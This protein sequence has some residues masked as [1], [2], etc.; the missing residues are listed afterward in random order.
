MKSLIY[1]IPEYKRCTM[2]SAILL[3]LIDDRFKNNYKQEITSN[4]LG[5]TL[6]SA[7]NSVLDSESDMVRSK[8]V[9]MREFENLLNEPIFRDEKIKNKKKKSD[10]FTLEVLKDFIH[11]LKKYV[12][13]LIAHPNIGYD[14]LGRFYIEFIR[15]AASEQKSGLVLTPS[16][17]T[18]LFCELAE[19]NIN[20]IVYDPCCGTGGFLV[21]AMQRLS[22]CCN[23]TII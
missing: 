8:T 18:E 21:A 15:Y 12:Y 5:Q 17:I 20:D 6:L 11:Y 23:A 3:A 2:I 16:H 14:V 1:S 9:L 4:E 22:S 7:I 10:E 19:L 13:P